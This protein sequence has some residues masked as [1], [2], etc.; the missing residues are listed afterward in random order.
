MDAKALDEHRPRRG[1]RRLPDAEY[2]ARRTGQLPGAGIVYIEK[3][4]LLM[5]FVIIATLGYGDFV[6]SDEHKLL[7]PLE[8]V[9][10]ILM[11]GVS[12]AI[13]MS[14]FQDAIRKTLEARR[15]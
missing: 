8:S 3:F 11:I 13:L 10:G 12:T 5:Y 2:G 15:G 1:A 9:N 4:Y 14:G 7:A 6:M